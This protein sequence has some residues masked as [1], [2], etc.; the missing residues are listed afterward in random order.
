MKELSFNYA[1]NE[2]EQ[3]DATRFIAALEFGSEVY[4][5]CIEWNHLISA[6]YLADILTGLILKWGSKDI[7]V[8]HPISGTKIMVFPKK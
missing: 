7:I 8:L 2:Q 3:K 4:A 6:S 1:L 5:E